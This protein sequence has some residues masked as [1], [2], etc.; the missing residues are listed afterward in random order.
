VLIGVLPNDFNTE[1]GN[2]MVEVRHQA[3]NKS[4]VAD[5]VLKSMSEPAALAEKGEVDFVLCVGDDRRSE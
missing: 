3:A 1:Q 5:R 2:R 4:M